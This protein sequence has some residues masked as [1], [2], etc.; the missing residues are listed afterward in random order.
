ML[1]FWGKFEQISKLFR[2]NDGMN[3]F[4]GEYNRYVSCVES[5][6]QFGRF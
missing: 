5:Y 2:K 3:D 1:T 4:S 6:N